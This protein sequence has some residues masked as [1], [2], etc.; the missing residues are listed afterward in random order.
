LW[1][2]SCHWPWRGSSRAGLL[3]LEVS[4]TASGSLGGMPFNNSLLTFRGTY[5]T[6]AVTHFVFPPYDPRFFPPSPPAEQWQAPLI[7]A[8]LTVAGFGTSAILGVG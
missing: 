5:D 2:W 6:A 4:G 7:S 1:P 8:S 3:Q